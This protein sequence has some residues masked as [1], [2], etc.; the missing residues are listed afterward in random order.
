[1]SDHWIEGQ[2]EGTYTGKRLASASARGGPRRFSFR[3]Q[4]GQVL[5]AG[6][7]AGPFP[8]DPSSDEV[9]EIRQDRVGRIRLSV[10]R[11]ELD[12]DETSLF[13]VRIVD[14]RLSRP[15][16]A[17]GQSHGRIE[18]TIRARLTPSQPEPSLEQLPDDVADAPAIEP[19][20]PPPA[21]ARGPE[22]RRRR[23]HDDA[24]PSLRSTEVEALD[25]ETIYDRLRWLA[26]TLVV[27]GVGAGLWRWCGAS[28]AATWLAAIGTALCLRRVAR[29]AIR[30]GSPSQ[31]LFA[32]A[33]VTAQAVLWLEPMARGASL[34][35]I[36][37]TSAQ[38][39]G[40]GGAVVAAGLLRGRGALGVTS[41]VWTAAICSWCAAL[42]G[43][44][45]V[46]AVAP[47]AMPGPQPAE[48]RPAPRTSPDGHWPVMPGRRHGGGGGGMSA[49]DFAGAAGAGA[50]SPS[51]SP[52]S[53]MSPG[54][55]GAF[56]GSEWDLGGAGLG[57]SGRTTGALDGGPAPANTVSDGSIS[58]ATSQPAVGD[59]ARLEN[60]R[61]AS[62]PPSEPVAPRR[63]GGASTRGG[64]VA[65]DHRRASAGAELIS[66]EHANRVPDAFFGSGGMRRVYVP[67]DPIFEPGGA[68]IR[69][70]GA[71]QLGRVAALLDLH[72]DR[73]TMLVVHTDVGGGLDAQQRL[74]ERRAA[75]VRGWLVDRGHVDAG[76][77]DVLGAGGAHP[78]VPPDGSYAAQ[79]PN[80]RIE[81]SLVE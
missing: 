12:Q 31:G 60:G 25:A 46:P 67:T 29:G 76:R 75:S 19:P 52:V 80:R 65:E 78:L 1:M 73:R 81:I 4:S 36:T 55:G 56:P 54:G 9:D 58:G 13:D 42:G 24:H 79:Q 69:A 64:W 3:L 53:P 49:P 38:L 63:G 35:C 32:G 21:G 27:L 15:A 10:P 77:F 41:I 28:M 45:T 48:H 33:L 51:T 6:V 66:I 18:G 59:V 20:S 22:P 70:T 44:C 30:A 39:A 37:P 68:D 7:V 26:A 14:W 71:L 11:L 61:A 5:E 47:A 17:N 57:G 74:S 23:R 34:G 72:P 8:D 62:T 50:S 2:F 40:L 43:A 16:E